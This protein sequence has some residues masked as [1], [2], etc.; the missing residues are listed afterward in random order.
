VLTHT[1]GDDVSIVFCRTE[2]ALL[3][4]LSREGKAVVVVE[5][6]QGSMPPVASVI[7]AIKLRFATVCVVGYCWLGPAASSEIVACARAGLDLLAPRGYH[8][9]AHVVRHALAEERGDEA[10][11]LHD[12]A[13]LLSPEQL[14]CARIV[15]ARA[16]EGPNV[17]LVAG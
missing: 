9:V 17:A 6:G 11:V 10:T 4:E 12:L 16:A 1:L 5:L 8:D 14:E 15:L 3:A 7:A 13:E 2:P